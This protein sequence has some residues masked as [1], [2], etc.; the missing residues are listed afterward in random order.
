MAPLGSAGN[1]STSP[2]L[3]ATEQ[4][5][6]F[7]QS[8][9]ET[10]EVTSPANWIA[11]TLMAPLDPLDTPMEDPHIRPYVPPHFE[12]AFLTCKSFQDES[13]ELEIWLKGQ[14][15]KITGD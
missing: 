10:P 13:Y 1:S 7:P 12:E 4:T 9:E 2:F 8:F 5:S 14:N 6:E 3:L 11:P 15:G